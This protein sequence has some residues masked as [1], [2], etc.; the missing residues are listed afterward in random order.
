MYSHEVESGG[1][2]V[3]KCAIENGIPE[4]HWKRLLAVPPGIT[5]VGV[6]ADSHGAIYLSDSDANKVF[7]FSTNGK[8]ALTYGR[9]NAQK[10]GSYDR[11][12]FIAPERLASWTDPDGHDRLLVLEGGGPNRVSEWSDDGRL[13]REWMVAQTKA[14]GGYAVDPRHPDLVYMPGQRD[15]LDRFRVDYK[16]GKWETDAVWPHVVTSVLDETNRF[17]LF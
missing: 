15:W 9:L 8:L 16:T 6:A 7:K 12:T 13:L 14:N 3:S 1:F 17:I 2:G 10:P 11:L 4:G 5:P